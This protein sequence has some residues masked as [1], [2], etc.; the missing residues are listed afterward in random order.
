MNVQP[1]KYEILYNG[2]NITGDIIQYVISL[3]YTDNSQGKADEMEIVLED[4]ANLWKNE[5]YPT[6]GDTIT[7]RIIHPE[8]G[9]LECGTFDIDEITGD[10][11][12][13]G[14]TF[15]IKGIAAGIKKTIRTKKSYAHE[16]KSLREIANHVASFHGLKLV[17]KIADVRI[18]RVTQWQETDLK[19]LRRIAGDYGYTFSIRD[20]QLIFT[21][22]FDLEK[23]E[24]SFTLNRTEITSWSITDKTSN[25]YQAA[26]V[27]FHHPRKKKTISHT[28]Q[29]K[30]E[31]HSSVKSDTLE[32]KVKAENEQQAEIKS[33]VAL[34]RANSL[35]QEGSVSIPGNIYAVAGN[36][37]ELNGI[38]MFSG[39]YYLDSTTHTVDASGGYTSEIS[40]KR[41]G[42][43][44][45][46][47]QKKEST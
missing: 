44:G 27:S 31:T 36:N 43:V 41:V 4:V 8:Q 11:G 10:A 29:E 25:T 33:R 38:G 45:K 7:A 5:W 20:K 1:V 47:K 37:C 39:L 21:S 14:D 12:D 16:N 34:Y 15:T 30:D 32:I 28:T 9:T 26:R 18:A 17:G 40:V 35:Q 22:V 13:A 19:F 24:A 6:K 2:K 23:K 3:T 46:A 42:L